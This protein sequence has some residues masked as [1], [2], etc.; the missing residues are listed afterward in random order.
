[1]DHYTF[2]VQFEDKEELYPYKPYGSDDDISSLDYCVMENGLKKLEEK[3]QER[4]NNYK[5]IKSIVI[6]KDGEK[7]DVYNYN[8]LVDYTYIKPIIDSV[9]IE[10]T[11]RVNHPEKDVAM[12]TDTDNEAFKSMEEYLYY[13]VEEDY[14]RLKYE[15]KKYTIFTNLLNKYKGIIDQPREYLSSEDNKELEEIKKNIHKELRVYRVYRKL[16]KYRFMYGKFYDLDSLNK[17]KPTNQSNEVIEEDEDYED[18]FI[19]ETEEEYKL[20]AGGD[21]D[22]DIYKSL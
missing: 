9:K 22:N 1:M 6:H 10:D 13:E 17:V 11:F 3:I 18:D 5:K 15:F 21:I 19:P 8:L 7:S 4:A 20:M 2:K 14:E 16:A 12:I